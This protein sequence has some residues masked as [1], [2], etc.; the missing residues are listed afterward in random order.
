MYHDGEIAIQARVGVQTEA[1]RIANILTPFISDT[2]RDLLQLQSM[3]IVSTIDAQNSIW[4]SLLTGEPGFIRAIDT[5]TLEI[6]AS[7][8]P[9][10][11]LSENLQP[12]SPVGMIVIDTLSRKRVRANGFITLSSS[13]HL[14]V[15]TEQVYFNC[16][17]YIQR[18]TITTAHSREEP[19]IYRTG[20]LT[21]RQQAWIRSADTF[22]IGSAHAEGGA[23][24]SHRGGRPGFVHIIGEDLLLFP[25]YSGNMMF[26]TLGNL[27]IDPRAGLLFIDFERGGTLQL[28]GKASIIWDEKIIASLPGAQRLLLFEIARVVEI[29]QASSIHGDLLGYSPFLP[30]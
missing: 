30:S 8:R 17:R 13:G 29:N 4:V 12:G 15:R 23:D 6:A 11:P 20:R 1:S 26:Q 9:G 24:A 10:D 18:R 7:P 5:T 19:S 21:E 2:V 25:D 22:F 14:R 27:A 28:T 16:P 3:I